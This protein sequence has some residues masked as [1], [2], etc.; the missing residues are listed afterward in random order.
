MKTDSESIELDIKRLNLK[1]DDILIVGL[2]FGVM[3]DSEMREFALNTRNSIRALIPNKI[4][5][6]DVNTSLLVLGTDEEK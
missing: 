6:T 4:M 5:I 2:N 3:N 1:A